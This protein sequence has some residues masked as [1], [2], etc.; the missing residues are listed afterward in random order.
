MCVM[1]IKVDYS[2]DCKKHG[3]MFLA[4]GVMPST[5]ANI[6]GTDGFSTARMQTLN[7]ASLM[8]GRWLNFLFIIDE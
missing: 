5:L 1:H 6:G 7:G 4:L 8:R 3:G 2:E